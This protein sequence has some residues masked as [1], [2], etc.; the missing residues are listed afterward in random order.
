MEDMGVLMNDFMKNC[1]DVIKQSSA[2]SKKDEK[3]IVDLQEE[4]SDC[5]D[6]KQMFRTETEMEASVLSKFQSVPAK[7]W[8]SVREQSSMFDN[9]VIQVCEA[10]E[11]EGQL[12]LLQIELSELKNTPKD[13]ANKKILTSQIKKKEITITRLKQSIH[14]RIVEIKHWEQLKQKFLK[15]EKFD[16]TDVETH[17]KESYKQR[18]K[19][20][21]ALG[22]NQY[23]NRINLN[24][25]DKLG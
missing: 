15:A 12:D 9:I 23:N 7:F 4:L 2:L 17:Q 8:Q 18:W 24:A 11:I 14:Y 10:Y 6:K 22:K 16:S 21:I 1:I 25:L 13:Y 5:F 3:T 20:E 19:N